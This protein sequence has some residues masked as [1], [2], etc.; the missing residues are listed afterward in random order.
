MRALSDKTGFT[1]IELLVTVLIIA[2]LAGAAMSVWGAKPKRQGVQAAAREVYALL[3]DARFEA[4]RTKQSVT[5]R[6]DGNN[7]VSSSDT[8]NDG[9]FEDRSLVEP[10]MDVILC[11]AIED[12]HFTPKG[13]LQDAAGQPT[14]LTITFGYKTCDGT[15]FRASVIT[16]PIGF[17]ELKYLPLN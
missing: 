6:A 5:I 10:P 11:S 3:Q 1:L 17:S 12:V 14:S 16:N 15:N 4:I 13:A 8:N 2:V 9:S 7:V